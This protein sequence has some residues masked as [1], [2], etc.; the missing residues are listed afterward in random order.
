M[1]AISMAMSSR[2]PRQYSIAQ[3]RD[4]LA[5]IVHDAEAGTPIELTRRGRPVAVIVSLEEYHRLAGGQKLEFWEAYERFRSETDLEDLGI[6][7]EVFDGVRD[8]SPG[9]APGW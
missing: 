5:G 4:Q 3:A 2:R 9:R 6:G 7:P 8:R 1:M